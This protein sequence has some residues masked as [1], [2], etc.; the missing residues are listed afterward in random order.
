M[1]RAGALEAAYAF[2]SDWVGY[3]FLMPGEDIAPADG[4]RRLASRLRGENA[5]ESRPAFA[6][7]DRTLLSGQN[8]LAH[9]TFSADLVPPYIDWMAKNKLGGRVL[10]LQGPSPALLEDAPGHTFVR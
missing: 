4:P 8:F 6:Y 2:L 9:D 3:R 1:D 5:I 10:L 7:R